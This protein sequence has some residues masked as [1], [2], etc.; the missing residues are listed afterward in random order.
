MNIKFNYLF[1][2]SFHNS[3]FSFRVK[4]QVFFWGV[5]KELSLLSLSI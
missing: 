5:D 2:N 4:K 3:K 1:F